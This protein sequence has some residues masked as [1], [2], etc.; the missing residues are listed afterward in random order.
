MRKFAD[1]TK[2][3][4]CILTEEDRDNLQDYL[5]LLHPVPRSC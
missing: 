4:Q 1:D 5:N 2:L 3:A